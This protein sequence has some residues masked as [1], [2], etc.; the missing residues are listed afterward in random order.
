MHGLLTALVLTA[1]P[2]APTDAECAPLPAQAAG[3][4]PFQAGEKLDY[5]IDL[6]GGLKIG[7]VEFEVQP[8]ERIGSELLLPIRAHAAGDGFVASIGKLESNATT[9]LRIHDLLPVRY[10]EDYTERG[11]HY[12]TDVHFTQASPCR[13]QFAFGQPN[14]SGEKSFPCGSEA[15]DLI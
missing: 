9:W 4:L 3:R 11:G 14:G 7:T 12:W 15:L 1:A 13:V 6:L 2:S 5:E 10:R 8:P